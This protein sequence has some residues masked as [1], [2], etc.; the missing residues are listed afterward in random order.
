MSP[1]ARRP[2]PAAPPVKLSSPGLLSRP[3]FVVEQAVQRTGAA[4][5]IAAYGTE[6]QKWKIRQLVNGELDDETAA[7]VR[8]QLDVIS[9]RVFRAQGSQ[10]GWT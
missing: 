5:L 4:Q 8:G 1:F 9:R 3:S 10:W 6:E 2:R 7:V